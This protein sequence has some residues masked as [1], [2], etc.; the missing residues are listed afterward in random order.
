VGERGYWLLDDRQQDGKNLWY[1]GGYLI[2]QYYEEDRT[3]L[4][5]WNQNNRHQF[6]AKGVE[7]ENQLILLTKVWEEKIY[8]SKHV[9]DTFNG[10]YFRMEDWNN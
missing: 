6:Y 2:S 1:N 4:V 8:I 5:R 9:N 3:E 10:N 7:G